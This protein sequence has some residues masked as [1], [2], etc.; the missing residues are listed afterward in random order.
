MKRMSWS[1]KAKTVLGTFGG[2]V[3]MTNAMSDPELYPGTAPLLPVL[4]DTE[5]LFVQ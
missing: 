3:E 2:Q 5:I 4:F 1:W